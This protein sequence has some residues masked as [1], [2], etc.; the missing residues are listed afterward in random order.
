MASR[1]PRGDAF[2]TA[3]VERDFFGHPHGHSV[4]KV[5]VPVIRFL[6]PASHP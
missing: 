3:P 2:T 1:Y 5:R 6:E 4:V